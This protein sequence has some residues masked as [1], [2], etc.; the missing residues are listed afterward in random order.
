MEMG[1]ME[2]NTNVSLYKYLKIRWNEMEVPFNIPI[3]FHP[4]SRFH[5]FEKGLCRK[6]KPKILAI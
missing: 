2:L 1:E 5:V 4:F 6:N 3:F